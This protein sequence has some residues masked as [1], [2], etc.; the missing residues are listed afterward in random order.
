MGLSLQKDNEGNEVTWACKL[1]S[2]QGQHSKPFR[3]LNEVRRGEVQ[4]SGPC[5]DTVRTHEHYGLSFQMA[6][7]WFEGMRQDDRNKVNTLATSVRSNTWEA[8]QLH[9]HNGLTSSLRCESGLAVSA[10]WRHGHPMSSKCHAQM[11]GRKVTRQGPR[12]GFPRSYSSKLQ[13]MNMRS[14]VKKHHVRSMEMLGHRTL[15]RYRVA[16]Q[17]YARL[18]HT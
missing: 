2:D 6:N 12:V 1:I 14:Q 3:D 16:G 17:G 4:A 10:A 15:E 13:D 11:C 5:M 9:A 18:Q 8:R 7:V